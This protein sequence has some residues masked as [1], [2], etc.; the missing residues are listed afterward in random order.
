M[1]DGIDFWNFYKYVFFVLTDFL[2]SSFQL[3][4]L[5]IVSKGSVLLSFDNDTTIRHIVPK[6]C[7]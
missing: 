5:D 1:P 4:V 3:M 7:L 6:L 2:C